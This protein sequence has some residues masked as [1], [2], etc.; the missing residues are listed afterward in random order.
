MIA[1]VNTEGSWDLNKK[2]AMKAK[3][4]KYIKKKAQK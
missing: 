3:Q 1:Q 4:Q 2:P